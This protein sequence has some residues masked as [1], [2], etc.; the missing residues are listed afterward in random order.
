[1]A[2]DEVSE[3][4][5]DEAD[6]HSSFIQFFEEFTCVEGVYKDVFVIDTCSY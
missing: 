4:D 6:E 1:M 2:S 5:A 3:T